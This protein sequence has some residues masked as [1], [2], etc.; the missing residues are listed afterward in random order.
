MNER[1]TIDF[2]IDLGTTNSAIAVFAD[3][4]VEV[5][6][7]N[8]N[9]ELTPSAVLIRAGGTEIVGKRAQEAVAVHEDQNAR[10]GF[11]RQMG[12]QTVHQFPAAGL[13][14]T[15]EQLSAAILKDLRAS[16]E[17]WSGTP[18]TSAVITVPANFELAQNEATQRAAALAG[19]DQ[20]P[21]LQEPIAAGLAYGYQRQVGDGLFMVFDLGGGTLDVSLLRIK[22]GLLSF[23]DQEGDNFLGGKDW[24]RR[25]A[26]HLY[27]E[28]E[29][30]YRIPARGER[31]RSPGYGRLLALAEDAKIRLSRLDRTDIVLDGQIADLNGRPIEATLTL[32]RADYEALIAP[33]VEKAARFTKSLL[34]RQRVEA[35]AVSRLVL[36]GGPTLTPMV[37]RVLTEELGIQLDTRIDPMTVVARGAAVFAGSVPI[38]GFGAPKE[39]GDARLKLRLAHPAVTGDTEALVGGRVENTTPPSG[40]QLEVRRA[41]GGWES[42]RIALTEQAFTVRVVLAQRVTNVFDL[43]AFDGNGDRLTL[44]PERFV[45]TQGLAAADPPLSR[46]IWLLGLDRET[47]E[48]AQQIMLRKGTAL[49]AVHQVSVHT[50]REVR[51]GI[52]ADALNI[53]VVEGEHDRRE[54]NRQVGRLQ[55][56]G[57]AVNRPLPEGTRIEVKVRVDASRGIV[58]SAYVPLLDLTIEDVLRDK[59]LPTVDANDLLADLDRELERAEEVAAGRDEDLEAIR[60]QADELRLEL[61]EA[62]ADQEQADRADR[63]LRELSASIDRLAKQTELERLEREVDSQVGWARKIAAATDDPVLKQRLQGLE[64]EASAAV[65]SRDPAR[66]RAAAEALDRYYWAVATSLPSFWVDSFISLQEVVAKSSRAQAAVPLLQAGRSALDRQDLEQLRQVC[67]ALWKLLPRQEQAMSGLHDIGIRF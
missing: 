58:A 66:M 47:G 59:Y 36:V 46:T 27:D 22:N 2:G 10:S 9:Q 41:D 65:S 43:R 17:A 29:S 13:T 5:I 35:A 25:L 45:I 40:T 1:T 4:Q 19:I 11:K 6:K 39:G 51:P 3:G 16:A 54:L 61:E 31:P 55:L 30:A 44:S 37:R 57:S 42:G 18:V 8:D 24:D 14:R 33:E 63:N 28:L 23:V 64:Q 15:A 12:K 38:A 32:T 62:K 21:L 67:A 7:N 60:T 53:Y 34:A 20:A 26:D 56:K 52:D 48:P 49:P 50:T